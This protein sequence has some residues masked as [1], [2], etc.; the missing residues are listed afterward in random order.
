M[1]CG[2]GRESGTERDLVALA[3]GAVS[4]EK[5]LRRSPDFPA[6]IEQRRALDPAD[7]VVRFEPPHDI[8]VAGV[9]QLHIVAVAKQSQV[10]EGYD[11]TSRGYFSMGCV[12]KPITERVLRDQ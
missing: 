12:S 11:L 2:P 9:F 3:V 7:H 5:H 8:V 1:R 4:D 6:W 10:I